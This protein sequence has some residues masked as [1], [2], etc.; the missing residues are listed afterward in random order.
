MKISII[1]L[2]PKMIECFLNESIVRRAQEAGLVDIELINL[3][4]FASDKYGTVDDK[5]YGGGPGMILKVDVIKRALDSVQ[6]NKSSYRILTS[7]KGSRFT[8]SKAIRYS[9]VE[10][11]IIISGHY[12]GVDKRVSEFVDEEVSLGDF[13]LTGGEIVTSAIVDATVRLI[14]HVLNE[15]SPVEESFFVISLD[16]LIEAVGEDMFLREL[17]EKGVKKVALLEY[18]QYTRPEIFQGK[19]VPKVLLSGNYKK[20]YKWRLKRAY[21]ETL[22]RRKDLL[23]R[24]YNENQ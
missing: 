9:K 1:T 20:I 7:A 3:R 2:F 16:K 13:I 15:E 10:H 11:L 5:P 4:S 6:S 14:P 17:R 18:P 21:E 19:H 8:Q 22:R 23:L 24:N 12:E